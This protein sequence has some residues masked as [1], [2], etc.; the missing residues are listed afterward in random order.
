MEN[1]LQHKRPKMYPHDHVMKAIVLPFVPQFVRPNYVTALRLMLIPIVLWLL[2]SQNY[3]V[4]IPVFLF[5][6]FTDALDGSIA[7]VRDQ[8]TAWGIFFDPVADKLLIGGV[9]L[10]VAL[11][12]FHPVLIFAAIILDIMPSVLWA[13]SRRSGIIMMANVWGKAKMVLQVISISSLLFGILFH[14]PDLIMAGQIILAVAIV[15]SLIAVVTY[16]L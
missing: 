8:I 15:F 11:K 10:V 13:A 1:S 9:A 4:G 3:T 12:Y 14:L 2:F 16:S 6:A 5:A 7:R